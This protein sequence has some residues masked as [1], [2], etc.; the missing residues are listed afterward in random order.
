MGFPAHELALGSDHRQD[1]DAIVTER[2][3]IRAFFAAIWSGAE[4]L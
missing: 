2:G 4:H 3:E 1:A